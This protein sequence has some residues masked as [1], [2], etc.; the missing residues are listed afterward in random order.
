MAHGAMSICG[1]S[2]GRFLL[3]FHPPTGLCYHE[4]V[5]SSKQSLEEARLVDMWGEHVRLPTRL[6]IL[7][8]KLDCPQSD[9][10]ADNPG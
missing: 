2:A 4:F 6:W 3:S 10:G 5:A 8:I 7:W 9:F 1:A